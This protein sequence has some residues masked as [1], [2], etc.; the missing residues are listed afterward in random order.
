MPVA[1]TIFFVADNNSAVDAN[2]SRMTAS[3]T[4]T[5]P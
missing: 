4:H 2:G 5:A 1:N 3:G